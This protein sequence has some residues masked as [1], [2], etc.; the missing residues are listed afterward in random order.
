MKKYA[1]T[2]LTRLI[3]ISNIIAVAAW[4]FLSEI[5]NKVIIPIPPSSQ[6]LDEYSDTKTISGFIERNLELGTVFL[7]KNYMCAI[8]FDDVVDFYKNEL[9]LNPKYW[10]VSKDKVNVSGSKKEWHISYVTKYRPRFPARD[11]NIST[12]KITITQYGH[13]LHIQKEMSETAENRISKTFTPSAQKEIFGFLRSSDEIKQRFGQEVLDVLHEGDAVLIEIRAKSIK[14]SRPKIK[15]KRFGEA[16]EI[17]Q[18]K[19][20]TEKDMAEIKPPEP[21]WHLGVNPDHKISRGGIIAREHGGAD[22]LGAPQFLIE[23]Y[24]T[25]ADSECLH[26][27]CDITK[28]QPGFPDS[29]ILSKTYKIPLT[30]E[31]QT[32]LN[33][34]LNSTLLITVSENADYITYQK[35]EYD[36]LIPI[37]M[38]MIWKEI[39][40]I[41]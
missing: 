24:Y 1:L 10:K 7:K 25:D 39:D 2:S 31:N 14:G 29:R 15:F 9:K 13:F 32:Y 12:I 20:E 26:V 21:K 18:Q 22:T 38:G 8:P 17:V 27:R 30:S 3:I 6:L 34:A 36:N 11:W 41:Q 33:V 28:Q 23:F 40:S 19:E 16:I 4:L 35:T 5:R 37:T